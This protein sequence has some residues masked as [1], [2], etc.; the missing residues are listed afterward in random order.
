M[1]VSAKISY[2]TLLFFKAACHANPGAEKNFA[3]SSLYI[4]I[5]IFLK[6]SNT[7]ANNKMYHLEDTNHDILLNVLFQN[8]YKLILDARDLHQ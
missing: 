2:F 7:S 4:L 3:G 5:H 6:F 8:L 1:S